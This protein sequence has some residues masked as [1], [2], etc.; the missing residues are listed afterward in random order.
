M[1]FIKTKKITIRV[2]KLLLIEE[3][4]RV[5]GSLLS[6]LHQSTIWNQSVLT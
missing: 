1:Y 3:I 2:M 5:Y 6:A 4:H